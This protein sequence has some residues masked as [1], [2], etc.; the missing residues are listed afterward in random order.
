MGNL[1]ER[2]GPHRTEVHGAAGGR[3][4][5]HRLQLPDAGPRLGH[6]AQGGPLGRRGHRHHGPHTQRLC[7]GPRDVRV[8]IEVSSSSQ[9]YYCIVGIPL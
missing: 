2:I 6:R 4:R 8:Y 3:G 7:G 1:P 9:L 5:G